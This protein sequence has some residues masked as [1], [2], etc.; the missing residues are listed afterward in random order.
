MM[1]SRAHTNHPFGG[2]ATPDTRP[3][4]IALRHRLTTVLPLSRMLR[5]LVSGFDFAGDTLTANR[6]HPSPLTKET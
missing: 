6:E 3:G 5:L 4:P 1:A 2:L